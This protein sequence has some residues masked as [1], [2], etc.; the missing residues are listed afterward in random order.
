MAIN[1]KAIADRL[2]SDALRYLTE[3]FP[4]G[5]R[6][7]HEFIVGSLRGE[8]GKSL[9]I[10]IDSGIWKD[11]ASGTGGADLISLYA[12]IHSIKQGD[13]A[14]KL[15]TEKDTL[16]EDSYLPK[17]ESTKIPDHSKFGKPIAIYE[18]RDIDGKIVGYVCRF[19]PLN[20]RKQFLPRSCWRRYDG[21]ATWKWKKWPGPSPI[22][23]LGYLLAN[24]E[25]KILI[26]EGEKTCQ[27]AQALLPDWVVISWAGGAEAIKSTNWSLLKSKSDIWMWPDAD[28]AGRAAAATLKGIIS[29]L[30]VVKLHPDVEKGWDLGDAPDGFDVEPHLIE[31]I[32]VPQKLSQGVTLEE[33]F[34]YLNSEYAVIMR[35]SQVLVMRHWLGEDNQSKLTL[36][37]QRDFLLWQENNVIYI[38]GA[39]GKTK[40]LKIG[41]EWLQWTGRQEFEEVYFEPCGPIY[42]KRYNLWQGFRCKPSPA[43]DFDLFLKHIHDNIC[44]HNE[45]YYAWVMAW[46][47]DL[48]QKP[49]RKLGTALVLRGA[50]GV[51][52]GVFASHIG[53]LLGKHYMPITQ[54]GQLTGKFNGHMADKLLMFVDEGWWSHEKSYGDG[55]LR[56]LITEHEVTIEMKGRDAITLPNYTRFIVGANADWVVPVGMGD[57]RRFVMLDVGANEQRNNEYFLAIAHQLKDGG[58]EALLHYFLNYKYDEKLPRSVLNT[59][60]LAE[61]KLYSMPNEI[62]W[63]HDCLQREKIG[64]FSLKI[65][66]FND[67]EC[68]KFYEHYLKWCERV[69]Q[70]AV[71]P[72]ILTRK[73]KPSIINIK[74]TRKITSV[75]GSRESFYEL[76]TLG[77]MRIYFEKYFGSKINWEE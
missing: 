58:Y 16:P 30:K 11:F 41:K 47:A 8:P 64:D 49:N 46:L 53:H 68:D 36:L 42:K 77:D 56:A 66:A 52:K 54:S 73:L 29:T 43:G 62:T 14:K 12:A 31:D 18:Y 35:G 48:F 9:S 6:Q 39:D 23:N 5:K 32:T 20:E 44:Q 67:I 75:T 70:T 28:D 27:R 72:N 13:A 45:E 71:A 21:T 69:K 55:I 59:D 24:P 63:W 34:D 19:E 51:G 60:V 17:V 76:Q 3:W 33:R 1:F 26:V 74:K 38:E 15:G 57:E 25:K 7:G 4:Q 37:S 2:L 65:N 10:N 22:Y 40:Q 61:T 50:M